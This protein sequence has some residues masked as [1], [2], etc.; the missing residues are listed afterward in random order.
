MVI[1]GFAIKDFKTPPADNEL[2]RNW[3]FVRQHSS[4]MTASQNIGEAFL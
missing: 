3:L 2:I 4:L 1:V